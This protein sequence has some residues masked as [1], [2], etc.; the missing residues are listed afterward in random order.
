MVADNR[1]EKQEIEKA[2]AKNR[3]PKNVLWD[4]VNVRADKANIDP[5]AKIITNLIVNSRK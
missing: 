5:R 1:Q 4:L 2:K 3:Q